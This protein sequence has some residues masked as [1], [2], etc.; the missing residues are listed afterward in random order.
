MGVRG[1]HWG[2]RSSE[3]ECRARTNGVQLLTVLPVARLCALNRYDVKMCDL[4]LRLIELMVP[5][6]AAAT[7]RSHR[8]EVSTLY[9]VWAHL[10]YLSRARRGQVWLVG[11]AC[12]NRRFGG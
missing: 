3:V 6:F 1:S 9:T 4:V 10:S 5:K 11:S 8:Y 12:H 2:R 7:M